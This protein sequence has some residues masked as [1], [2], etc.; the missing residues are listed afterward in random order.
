MNYDT[1]LLQGEPGNAECEEETEEE[2]EEREYYDDLKCDER[3]LK[4]Q[5]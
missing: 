3:K 5:E 2:L 1:W 4:E